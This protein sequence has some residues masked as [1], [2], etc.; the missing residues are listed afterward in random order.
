MDL[1]KSIANPLT[2]P[3]VQ[4]IAHTPVSPNALTLIGF[5]ITVGAAVLIGTGHLFAAGWV[6]LF[7]GVF[8]MLDG[9]LA[10]FS[11]KVTQF[12]AAFDS[13]LD[14]LSEASLMVGIMAWY[15]G[16]NNQLMVILAGVTLA[17]SFMVSYVRA[18]AEGLGLELKEGLFTRAERVI[19][20][21]LGLLL[22]SFFN[23]LGIALG[24]IAVLSFFTAGAAAV[25]GKA[26]AE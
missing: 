7:A 26:K 9:A 15:G 19:V 5:L 14:R 4:L 2:R 22:S 17:G 3:V 18:R 10:R 8:D 23:I 12:G 20:L 1:R 21:S 6:V 16:Q 24:I 11:G 13:S 25:A